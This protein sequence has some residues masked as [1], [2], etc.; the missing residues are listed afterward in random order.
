MKRLTLVALCFLLVGCGPKLVRQPI[1]RATLA[2]GL[3]VIH[4]Q[5]ETTPVV[6]RLR[7]AGPGAVMVTA[8]R[9]IDE[10]GREWDAEVLARELMG[11]GIAGSGGCREKGRQ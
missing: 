2:G 7:A 10:T 4:Y 6:L 11:A 3:E 5:T 1:S 9:R 8:V